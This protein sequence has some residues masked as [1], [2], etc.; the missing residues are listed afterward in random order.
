MYA[1]QQGHR[2]LLCVRVYFF[3]PP[4]RSRGCT[5]LL[6]LLFVCVGPAPVLSG[7]SAPSAV[8]SA[9][10]SARPSACLPVSYN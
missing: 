7:L 1:I 8:S 10:L 2:R 9:C 5:G 6:S 4:F 3:L